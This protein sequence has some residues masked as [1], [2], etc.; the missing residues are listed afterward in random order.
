MTKIDIAKVCHAA[1]KIICELNDDFSRKDWNDSEKWQTDS[2]ILGVEYIINNPNPSDS[3]LHDSWSNE[4]IAAGWKYGPIKDANLKTH[5]CLVP[6]ESLPKFQ[7][8]KDALFAG[9]C[10]SL[11][12]YLD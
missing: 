12:K 4:R 8:A 10:K 5:P 9:I 7:Q 2:S 3:I 11:I 1:N 6:F